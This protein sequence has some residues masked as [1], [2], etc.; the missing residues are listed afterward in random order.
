[1]PAWKSRKALFLLIPVAALTV[2]GA[3]AYIRTSASSQAQSD[4]Q[5]FQTSVARRGSL[6]VTASG[7]GKLVPANEVT[8]GFETS[9]QMSQ[10]LVQV[11][12]QVQ[13]GQVLARLDDTSA[14]QAL[15]EAETALREL[16]SPMAVAQAQL[17]VADAEDAL[18]TA[19][20]TYTVQQPGNRATSDTID[21]AKARLQMAKEKLAEAKDAYDRAKTSGDK[22]LAYDRYASAKTSYNSALATYNWYTGHPTEIQQAQ[23]AGE[24]ALA[25][26]QLDEAKALL[27]AL[28]GGALPEGA[29]GS[30]LTALQNA[31]AKV[32]SARQVLQATE[33]RAPIAGTVTAIDA[34]VGETVG[35]SPVVT[36]MDLSQPHVEFYLDET[37]IAKAATGEDVEVIFDAYPDVTF[38]GRVTSIDPV[39]TSSGGVGA[40]HG[41]AV[42][43]PVEGDS[44]PRLLVGQSASV[45]VIAAKV[46]DAV[47]VPVE[48]LRELA[49]GSYAVFVVDSSG[50]LTMRTVTVALQDETFAA[51]TSGL[52]AGETVSTGKV[53][54]TS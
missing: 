10:L 41:Y 46:D 51:I 48:A 16:T 47:L 30:G 33:L 25:Q 11:G 50:G 28:Q 31:Q 7:T 15:T 14:Q 27:A 43:T 13:A 19:Q 8:A 37:D 39:L 45:D 42:L 32:A 3:A 21:G 40:V 36:L 34:T 29:S 1:M 20:Y 6:S 49:P 35:S 12:D 9:G 53:Q 5:A 17:A 52:Q 23:L 24:V 22:A 44:A 4:G 18:K 2:V 26:A 38:N 54:V